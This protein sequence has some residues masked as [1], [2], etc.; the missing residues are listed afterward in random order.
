MGSLRFLL[1]AIVL[2]FHVGGAG[3]LSGR[4]AVM[5]F[6]VVSGFLI[7]RVFAERY[8]GKPIAFVIN[9]LL[10]IY[11]L[12][13]FLV[14][15][16]FLAYEFGGPVSPDWGAGA[17]WL[18]ARPELNRSDLVLFPNLNFGD[19]WPRLAASEGVIPQAWSLAVEM[20]FYLLPLTF[21]LV[22]R[23][24][25]LWS[26]LVGSFAYYLMGTWWQ[27]ESFRDYDNVVYKD[28]LKTAWLFAF[29]GLLYVYG[30]RLP[31]MRTVVPGLIALVILLLGVGGNRYA[32]GFM[33]SGH[34]GWRLA[35]VLMTCLTALIVA[36][37]IGTDQDG[38]VQRF[39][40]DLSYGIYL[41]HL[42]VAW[43][44][45]WLSETIGLPLFG[46][47]NEIGFGLSALLFSVAFAYVTFM[48][49][50]KPIGR[51]RDRIRPG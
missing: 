2:L 3:P 19:G 50:E 28:A 44:L 30:D 39:W 31:K 51:Y 5:G 16:S 25:V 4:L 24:L 17:D 15:L 22:P 37:I 18:P 42:L 11:P 26:V 45:I 40:G 46:R 20:A 43:T 34:D 7:S 36:G 12:F 14:V 21:L 38:R 48:L 41:N 23:K 6:Y 1:A 13:F 33:H 9:R 29:G 49:V 47:M 32:V 8:S 10:R 27:A 35:I